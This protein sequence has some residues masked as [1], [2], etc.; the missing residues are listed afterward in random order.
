M[1]IRQVADRRHVHRR[2]VRRAL[3]EPA[4]PSPRKRLT[5]PARAIGPI[6]DVLDKLAGEPLTI[7]EIWTTATGEHDFD[8][9]CP[10]VRDYIQ[11]RRLAGQLGPPPDQDCPCRSI[12]LGPPRCGEDTFSGEVVMPGSPIRLGEVVRT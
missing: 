11:A 2:M 9:S 12:V 5:R 3:A 10:A 7:W 8:A 1:S 6:Q 4:G